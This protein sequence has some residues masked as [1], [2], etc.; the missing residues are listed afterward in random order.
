MVMDSFILSFLSVPFF[1][2]FTHLRDT[3]PNHALYEGVFPIG[4]E[5]VVGAFHDMKAHLVTGGLEAVCIGD[6]LIPEGVDL[7]GFNVGF[8]QV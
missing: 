4:I 6:G 5:A 7:L 2:H 8:R 3:P 1:Q